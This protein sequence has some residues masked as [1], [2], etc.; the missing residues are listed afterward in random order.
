MWH[1]I[2]SFKN[3]FLIIDNKNHPNFK[4]KI[5]NILNIILGT[6]SCKSKFELHDSKFCCEIF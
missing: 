5:I 3:E 6:Y 2:T 1:K 4:M